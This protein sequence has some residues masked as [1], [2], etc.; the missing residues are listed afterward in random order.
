VAEQATRTVAGTSPAGSLAHGTAEAH[1][2]GKPMSWVAVSVIIVGFVIGGIAMVPHPIWWLF[3]LGAGIAIV[4][5]LMTLVAKT[6]S[7][8]WY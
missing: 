4:G 5:C 2:H 3:W 7:E 1:H 8:D 6:F